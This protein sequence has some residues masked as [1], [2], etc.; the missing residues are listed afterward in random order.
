M[1]I[2]AFQRRVF[3]LLKAQIYTLK[4]MSKQLCAVHNVV[5]DSSTS[6]LN[7]T[8]ASSSNISPGNMYFDLPCVTELDLQSLERDIGDAQKCEFLVRTMY[9]HN[10]QVL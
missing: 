9:K 8:T 5:S 2:S 6:S 10:S 3:Q 4:Q 7:N 1:L